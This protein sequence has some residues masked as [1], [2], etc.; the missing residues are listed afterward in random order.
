MTAGGRSHGAGRGDSAKAAIPDHV[1]AILERWLDN[2]SNPSTGEILPEELT[3]SYGGLAR[4]VLEHGLDESKRGTSL[5]DDELDLR[6]AA[7]ALR[8]RRAGQSISSTVRRFGHLTKEVLDYL[9][10]SGEM[11]EDVE[12]ALRTAMS[13]DEVMEASLNRLV[14][15]LEES[16]IRAHEER[17]RAMAAVM[18]VLSHEL[19]N[20]LGAARTAADMLGSAR[21]EL[22][23]DDLDKIGSLVRS[24]LDDAMRTV[25]DVE[26]LVEAWG[27]TGAEAGR[28][29]VPLSVLLRRLVDELEPIAAELGVRLVLAS[30]QVDEPVDA[31][32]LRLILYNLVSNGIKYHDPSRADPRVEVESDLVGNDRIR[33]RVRDN[34]IGIAPEDHETIFHPRARVDDSVEGSGLGLAIVR[35]AAEQLGGDIRLQSEIGEGTTFTLILDEPPGEA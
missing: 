2:L 17:G 16:A 8:S 23:S 5:S 25:D 19:E 6:L 7:V 18:D 10:E 14:R 32:R 21:I 9:T 27:G 34:G 30:E 12:E 28:Q 20:R 15:V 24:S 29:L 1:E 26:A 35:E 3:A 22:T 31:P 33:I 13:V 4:M 11:S